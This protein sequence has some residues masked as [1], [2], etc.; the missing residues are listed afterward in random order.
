MFSSL[1]P[2]HE[3]AFPKYLAD[4]YLDPAVFRLRDAIRRWNQRIPFPM[5][6]DLNVF[7]LYTFAHNIISHGFST[8][9]GK[10]AV[11]FIWPDSVGMS[12]DDDIY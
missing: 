2:A 10:S 6:S 7:G 9:E 12:T 5:V 11:I 1:M 3:S 4:G 8:P